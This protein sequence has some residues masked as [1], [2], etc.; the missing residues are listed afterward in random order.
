[1]TWHPYGPW[2]LYVAVAGDYCK[3]G[4]SRTPEHR[5]VSLQAACPL[6]INMIHCVTMEHE[7]I[8][9]RVTESNIHAKLTALGLRVHG[10]WFV[11]DE[12]AQRCLYV[13]LGH[14]R[15]QQQGDMA[16]LSAYQNNQPKPRELVS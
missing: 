1:M 15:I 2:F 16:R 11:Y 6:K 3:V 14:M 7:H 8:S 10:E 4:L 13:E 12:Q 9:A 5:M